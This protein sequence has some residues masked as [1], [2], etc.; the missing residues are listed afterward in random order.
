MLPSEEKEE[1]HMAEFWNG[2]KSLILSVWTVR[3]LIVALFVA[4]VALP[5]LISEYLDYAGRPN[6]L[7]APTLVALYLT[8]IAAMIVLFSLQ[9]LLYNIRQDEVFVPE[10]VRILRLISWCCFAVAL[11]FA[12][13][14]IAYLFSLVIAVAALFIAL[15]LRVLKNVFS[16]AV[17]LKAENDYTI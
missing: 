11:I 7:L 3:I 10:N 12:L 9:R 5:H 14:S 1:F 2:K 8:A 4:M 17:E 13:L 16:I 6:S 15:I